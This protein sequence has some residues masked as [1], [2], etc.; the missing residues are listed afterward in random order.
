MLQLPSD[1]IPFHFT[2]GAGQVWPSVD[3]CDV[4]EPVVQTDTQTRGVRGRQLLWSWDGPFIPAIHSAFTAPL[5]AA[6]CNLPV[7]PCRFPFSCAW[8]LVAFPAHIRDCIHSCHQG[9]RVG[10]WS[11]QPLLWPLMGYFPNAN[12]AGSKRDAAAYPPWGQLL[13]HTPDDTHFRGGGPLLSSDLIS[14]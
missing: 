7:S 2:E 11:E 12:P 13:L 1:T 5:T 10:R 6:P 8:Q 4:R 3:A 9:G 14:Q